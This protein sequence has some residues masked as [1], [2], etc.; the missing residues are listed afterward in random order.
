MSQIFA[1]QSHQVRTFTENNETWFAAIDVCRA[2]SISWSGRKILRGFP[3]AWQR[4]VK[5]TTHRR[6]DQQT[7]MVSEPAVYK[8]AFRSNKPEA[9]AFTNW[10][11]SE[12]LPA[13]RKTGTFNV[14]PKQKALPAPTPEDSPYLSDNFAEMERDILDIE[15]KIEALCV[16]LHLFARPSGILVSV[17]NRNKALIDAA[18]ANAAAAKSA[19]GTGYFMLQAVRRICAAIK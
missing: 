17:Y 16:R 1:Y 2:L 15:K 18:S 12:V 7:V 13:I 5:L 19:C 14:K 4:V 8:L 9:D 3:D 6:G 11:A 10:V